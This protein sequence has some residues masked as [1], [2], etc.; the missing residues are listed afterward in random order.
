VETY[1]WWVTRIT[2]IVMAITTLKAT[3]ESELAVEKRGAAVRLVDS[4]QFEGQA[5]NPENPLSR[6]F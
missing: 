4:S 1:S 2:E 3:T 6:V 5:R